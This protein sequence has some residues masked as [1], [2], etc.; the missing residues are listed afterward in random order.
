M[1]DQ[2]PEDFAREVVA[3]DDLSVNEKMQAAVGHRYHWVRDNPRRECIAVNCKATNCRKKCTKCR[4][5]RYCS[6]ACLKEDWMLKHEIECA[7]YCMQKTKTPEEQEWIWAMGGVK[8]QNDVDPTSL[9]ARVENMMKHCSRDLCT[10]ADAHKKCS[11]CR[12]AHYCS[13]ECQKIDW[14]ARHKKEC[15]MIAEARSGAI[16]IGLLDDDGSPL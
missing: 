10:S 11:V 4:V 1:S 2:R 7:V 16:E 6:K 5:A 13:V 15:P 3:R 14:H 8:Y 12:L 9:V